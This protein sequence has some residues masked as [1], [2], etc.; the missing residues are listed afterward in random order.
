MLAGQLN[1]LLLGRIIS[2]SGGLFIPQFLLPPL[3]VAQVD[4]ELF[5]QHLSAV[6]DLVE[7]L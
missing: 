1:M 7:Y 2:W 5:P 3:S 4:R 6:D